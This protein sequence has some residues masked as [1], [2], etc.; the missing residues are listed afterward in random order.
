MRAGPI[1]AIV[2]S[3]AASEAPWPAR[4]PP[5]YDARASE[6][7]PPRAKKNWSDGAARLARNETVATWAR[8][9]IHPPV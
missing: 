1:T 4:A 9:I 3:M 2:C 7:P 5:V 8:P 6:M